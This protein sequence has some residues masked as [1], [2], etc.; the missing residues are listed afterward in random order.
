MDVRRDA[1]YRSDAPAVSDASGN[2]REGREKCGLK[3]EVT[4]KEQAVVLKIG[5]EA[6]GIVEFN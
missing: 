5:V 6:V 3:V 2:C 4:V 1:A